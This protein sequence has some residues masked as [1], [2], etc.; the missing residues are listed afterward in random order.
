MWLDE[1]FAAGFLTTEGCHLYTLFCWG[2]MIQFHHTVWS[3]R[4]RRRCTQCSTCT[5]PMLMLASVE[6]TG[7]VIL[8]EILFKFF[9]ILFSSR[10]RWFFG[11]W[12][13]LRQTH[14][15][16]GGR[17]AIERVLHW[18]GCWSWGTSPTVGNLSVIILNAMHASLLRY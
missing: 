5:Y 4:L 8:E 12:R 18:S 13:C 6:S 14:S 16:W 15:F 1:S 3:I 9:T 11:A 7:A 10:D 17:T 2:L